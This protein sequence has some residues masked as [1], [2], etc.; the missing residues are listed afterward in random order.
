MYILLKLSDA[1]LLP[2]VRNILREPHITEV[3]ANERLD[4]LVESDQV[5]AIREDE[6]VAKLKE[7]IQARRPSEVLAMPDE[8]EPVPIIVTD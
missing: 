3:I 8:G 6:F 1:N 7:T 5:V 4:T 2:L